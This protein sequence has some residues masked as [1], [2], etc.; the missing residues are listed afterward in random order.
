MRLDQAEKNSF[1]LAVFKRLFDAAPRSE[2]YFKQSNTRL[3]FIVSRALEMSMEIYQEPT[4]LANDVTSLGIR[5]IMWNIP[6]TFFEPF[7]QAMLDECLFRYSTHPLGVEGLEWA[8]R[9]IAGI[10]VQTID[11]GSSPLIE[12]V[13]R[14]RPKAV[15]KALA[16]YPRRDRAIACL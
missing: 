10:M 7:L 14:N 5:H 8:L 13:V 6:T 12:A 15:K 2:S 1:G 3:C 4:R 11:E 16:D 9:I